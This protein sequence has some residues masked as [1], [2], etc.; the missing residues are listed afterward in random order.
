[1]KSSISAPAL[2]IS[3]RKKTRL[4]TPQQ[5]LILWL[6]CSAI[7][8][9]AFD[10]SIVNLALPVIATDLRI[11]LATT[12]WIQTVY[13]LSFGGFLLLGG[14][15]CDYTGSRRI[16][17][18]GMFLFGAA[19]AIAL[20]S[21]HISLLLLARAGQG[22][23]AALAMP[24]GISLLA[25]HFREGPE[26]Q[27]AIGIF[28]AFAAVGFAGGLALGG[29]IASFFNWHWIF[30]VNVPVITG[31]L[32]AGYFFI[33]EEKIKNKAPLNLLTA[34]W[35]TATLLL[36]CYTIH[37]LT[38]LGWT[39]LPCLTTAFL[40]GIELIRYDK[41][42]QQPFFPLNLFSTPSAYKA[43]G[44]SFLLG[45]CFLSFIF[46]CTLSLF[47]VMH[48]DIR[49]TG[50]LLFPYSIGSALVSKLLLPRLFRHIRVVQ[51]GRLAMLCLLGGILLLMVGIYTHH[52]AWFLAALLLV[53]SLCIAIGYPAFTILSLSGVPPAHQGMAAG[54]QSATY[55]VG[56]AMG[57]SVIGLCL[58]SFPPPPPTANH[59]LLT[60]VQGAYGAFWTSGAVVAAGCMTALFLLAGR[61]S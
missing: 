8:F 13:L 60:F 29:L 33:P 23:G 14:R 52:L 27:T 26:R 3:G 56:T 34:V 49:S 15:L 21:Q 9:E 31:V 5:R 40:S 18:T 38:R 53:N 43:L 2:T 45:A 6:A 1:M 47:E 51:A 46:L 20:V 39:L 57:L 17:M 25:R 50:L 61:K 32:I 30:G 44:A 59:L 24:G 37:E 22:I 48:L 16:F 54:L 42:Q 11:S 10:V 19:S 12:Q 4:F 58:Q 35:L 41:R 55:T 36:C 28:G 7:F